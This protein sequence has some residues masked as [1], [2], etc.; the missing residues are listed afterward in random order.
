MHFRQ[1]AP[2][3]RDV[4]IDV[5]LNQPQPPSLP[6]DEHGQAVLIRLEGFSNEQIAAFLKRSLRTVGRYLQRV[7]ELWGWAVG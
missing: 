7:R 6:D 1:T 2:Q 3:S 4:I 5:L